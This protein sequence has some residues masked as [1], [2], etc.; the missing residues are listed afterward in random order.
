L[1]ADASG[2]RLEPSFPVGMVAN[3]RPG[4]FDHRRS[5]FTTPLL[6]DTPGAMSLAGSVY[7]GTQGA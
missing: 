7:T 4:S 2:Q 6:G 3:G 5:E 1:L